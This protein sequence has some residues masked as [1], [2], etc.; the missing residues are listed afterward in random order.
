LLEIKAT[1]ALPVAIVHFPNTNPSIVDQNSVTRDDDMHLVAIFF[2]LPL[3]APL[4][5]I[6]LMLGNTAEGLD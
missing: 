6:P 2:M 1:E 5:H 3:L 4:L